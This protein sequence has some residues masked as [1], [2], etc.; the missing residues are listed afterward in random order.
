MIRVLNARGILLGFFMEIWSMV[1]VAMFHFEGKLCEIKWETILTFY[2]GRR[3]HK[4]E[5]ESRVGHALQE[6]KR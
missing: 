4:S 2:V 3:K 1:D 6:G 5:V